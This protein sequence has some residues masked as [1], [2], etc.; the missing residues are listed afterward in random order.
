MTTLRNPLFRELYIDTV[1]QFISI[2]QRHH[3]KKCP[4]N[5]AMNFNYG[6]F[7]CINKLVKEYQNTP[8]NIL[9]GR[10]DNN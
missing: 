3:S 10:L 6:D 8:D 2:N 4:D 5:S 9:P 7:V 1:C